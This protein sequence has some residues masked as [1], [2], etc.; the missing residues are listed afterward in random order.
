MMQRQTQHMVRLIDDLLD[1]SRI[2]R[3]KLELRRSHV[4][5]TDVVRNAVEATRPL[6]DEAGHHL[7]LRLP[8]EPILLYA[9]AGRLT[10]VFTNLLNNAAKYTPRQ[11][12]VELAASRSGAEVTV[13]ISDSGVGIPSDKLDN[14]FEMFAQIHESSEYGHTGLGIGLTLVK[15]L[16]EMH[17]GSVE[18]QSRGQNLG[19][20]FHVRLPVLPEPFPA[21]SGAETTSK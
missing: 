20:T 5:L 10:Q 16:V 11:G 7:A 8:D 15:R 17:G 6:M 12:R 14:V 4:E 19:T 2:T 21:E 1:V 3:G 9:D 18:V 13:S